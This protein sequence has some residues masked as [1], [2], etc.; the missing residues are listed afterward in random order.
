MFRKTDIKINTSLNHEGKCLVEVIKTEQKKKFIKQY[1][2]NSNQLSTLQYYINEK[3]IPH[4]IINQDNLLNN[5]DNL[6]NNQN[7]VEYENKLSFSHPEY[8]S[9]QLSS[10][11]AYKQTLQAKYNQ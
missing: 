11:D 7:L 6:L 9:N 10:L 1:Y 5:Q 2:L 8:K 3:N 4:K